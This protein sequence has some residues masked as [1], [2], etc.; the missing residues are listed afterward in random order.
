MA[1][2]RESV[3]VRQSAAVTGT[4]P[5]HTASRRT[6]SSAGELA[7]VTGSAAALRPEWCLATSAGV[8]RSRRHCLRSIR[9][10]R[11]H[12]QRE[13]ERRLPQR[14][15]HLPVSTAHR[16]T[17]RHSRPNYPQRQRSHKH[18]RPHY[19]QKQRTELSKEIADR[20]IH[21]HSGANYHK[22]S[23]G[24]YLVSEDRII[25]RLDIITSTLIATVFVV[26]VVVCVK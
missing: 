17:C 4:A 3:P 6:L 19:P 24:N 15:P 1:H 2:V 8:G 11:R 9:G 5:D 16:V 7:F 22:H 23:D 10:T 13:A 20:I 21:R 14:E 25:H 18:S 26:E 12:I